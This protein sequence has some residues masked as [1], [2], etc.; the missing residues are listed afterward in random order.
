MIIFLDWIYIL[1]KSLK[2]FCF[3]KIANNQ[4]Q[5]FYKISTDGN[6]LI[7]VLKWYMVQKMSWHNFKHWQD[8]ITILQPVKPRKVNDSEFSYFCTVLSKNC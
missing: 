8:I 6:M 1:L 2:Y 4:L 7:N 3:I 5:D